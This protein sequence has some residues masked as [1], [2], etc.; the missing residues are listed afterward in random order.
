MPARKREKQK[1]TACIIISRT[2]FDCSSP[3]M[4]GDFQELC[5]CCGTDHPD[6]LILFLCS[7]IFSL[8]CKGREN[9][10]ACAVS[11]PSPWVGQKDLRLTHQEQ[12][13]C[14]REDHCPISYSLGLSRTPGAVQ[15]RKENLANSHRFA[16]KNPAAKP[17]QVQL[18]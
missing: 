3:G 6:R 15:L 7:L 4:G 1:L 2:F 11:S 5:S 12:R 13:F 14:R 18:P 8:L 9:I 17:G 16:I 10:K